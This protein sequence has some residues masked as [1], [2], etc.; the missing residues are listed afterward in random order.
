MNPEDRNR[1]FQPPKETTY[2]SAGA[3]E[4]NTEEVVPT[5]SESTPVSTG[6]VEATV[7]DAQAEQA[8]EEE[9]GEVIH[10]QAAEYIHRQKGL[11]WFVV[12]GLVV[13]ALMAAAIFLF[14]AWTFAVLLPIMAFAL[15]TYSYRPPHMVNY[16][17]SQKGLYINDT[18]HSFAEFKAFGIVKDDG[19][20]SLEFIPVRRFRPSLSVYFPEETGEAIVDLL[21]VRLPMQQ[22]KPDAF[23]RIVRFLGL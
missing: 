10:W 8:V 7:E 12:F 23:D 22:L 21:G 15:V 1:D 5:Q 16:T 4:E 20:F 9:D 13:V 14:D 6:V 2:F 3:S 17:L 11:T 19:E 18:L